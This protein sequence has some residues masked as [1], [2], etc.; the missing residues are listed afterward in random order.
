MAQM[1][2]ARLS[3]GRIF[4]RVALAALLVSH[5]CA[6]HNAC[7]YAT[8]PNCGDQGGSATCA[9]VVSGQ[10]TNT[11]A[12]GGGNLLRSYI[13]ECEQLQASVKYYT[14]ADC[15]GDEDQSVFFPGMGCRPFVFGKA[16]ASFIFTCPTWATDD[17]DT[18]EDDVSEDDDDDG[19]ND[20]TGDTTV[21]I[22]AAWIASN[23][24]GFEVHADSTLQNVLCYGA[25][26]CAT[27]GHVVDHGGQLVTMSELCDTE[28]CTRSTMLVN[29]VQHVRS[30]L[31]PCD[32]SVCM[33]TLDAREN[34]TWKKVENRVVRFLLGLEHAGL[35]HQ[36]TKIQLS[37]AASA[38]RSHGS[39]SPRR[40]TTK[41]RLH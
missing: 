31:M 18:G 26:P 21:C 5:V 13:I 40:V 20:G 9:P 41:V 12:Q 19:E 8:D 17:D 34:T 25:L 6:D 3:R 35:S 11:N 28:A 32:G 7:Y 27:G 1:R 22:D 33:T 24:A 2:G 23:H 16:D 10:C 15:T 38:A 29:G 39:S 14:G 37:A 36:L 4:G 30:H